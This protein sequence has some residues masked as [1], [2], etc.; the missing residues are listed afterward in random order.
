MPRQRIDRPGD[1]VG[2]AHEGVVEAASRQHVGHD[3]RGIERL[4]I[5]APADGA[6]ER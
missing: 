2:V 1:A 6:D 5:L 4:V 3:T